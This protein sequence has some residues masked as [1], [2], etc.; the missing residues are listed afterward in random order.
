MRTCHEDLSAWAAAQ[1]ALIRQHRLAEADLDHLA[2]GLETMSRSVRRELVSRLAVLVAHL[3]KWSHQPD[4][5]SKRWAATIKGQRLE[6]EGLLEE[7]PSLT[8]GLTESLARADPQAVAWATAE[9]GLAETTFPP[10]CPF[11]ADQ[12]L[13]PAFLPE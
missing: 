5:R 8:A 13:A 1:A 4:R 6:I 10:A 3:L 2:E 9:T 11:R 12:V 7:S